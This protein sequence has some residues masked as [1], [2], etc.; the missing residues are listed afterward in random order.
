MRTYLTPDISRNLEK[1]IIMGDVRAEIALAMHFLHERPPLVC[2]CYTS[3]FRNSKTVQFC[4]HS[5]NTVKL[6]EL[7]P[8]ND[9]I[10]LV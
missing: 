3:I 7:D 9:I 4:M 6:Q 1:I 10:D 5:G 8:L 2:F